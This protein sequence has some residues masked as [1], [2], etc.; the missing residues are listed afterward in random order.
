MLTGYRSMPQG[1]APVLAGLFAHLDDEAAA[2]PGEAALFVHCVA[3]KDR[4]GFVVA[5]LLWA[6]G[7]SHEDIMSDYLASTP[8]AP[9]RRRLADPEREVAPDS[10][11]ERERMRRASAVMAGVDRLYLEEAWAETAR[12]HGSIERYLSEAAGL[13]AAR[14][15]RVREHLLVR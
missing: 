10:P 11:A 8:Y 9:P 13:D 15:T 14:R 3:G 4:T 2:R 6:L 7:A 1:F 5:M 12:L